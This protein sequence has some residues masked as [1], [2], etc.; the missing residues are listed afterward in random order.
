MDEI[1]NDLHRLMFLCVISGLVL[2]FIVGALGCPK[3]K[4]KR[5]SKYPPCRCGDPNHCTT[6]CHAKHLFKKDSDA[7]II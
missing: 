6:Y 3:R 4:K 2:G 7:G 5:K 1:I